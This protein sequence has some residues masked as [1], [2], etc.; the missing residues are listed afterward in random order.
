MGT[1]SS[2]GHRIRHEWAGEYFHYSRRHL[3]FDT[4]TTSGANSH[5]VAITT[6]GAGNHLTT[7]VGLTGNDNWTLTSGGNIT[8]G[9]G[10]SQRSAVLAATGDVAVN[11]WCMVSGSPGFSSSGAAGHTHDIGSWYTPA[12][13]KMLRSTTRAISILST[14]VLWEAG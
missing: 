10:F 8:L 13:D 4:V 5:T 3:R 14:D 12:A 11:G 9:A 2:S 1:G 7:T 6:T